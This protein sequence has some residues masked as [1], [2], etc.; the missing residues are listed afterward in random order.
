MIAINQLD[1][2]L[3]QSVYKGGKLLEPGVA[4]PGTGVTPAPEMDVRSSATNLASVAV[5]ERQRLK[6]I[7]TVPVT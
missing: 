6:V 4:R 3:I 7:E 5:F 1:V 2:R